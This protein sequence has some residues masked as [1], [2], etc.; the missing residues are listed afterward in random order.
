[1]AQTPSAHT[2]AAVS[3]VPTPAETAWPPVVPPPVTGSLT[4]GGAETLTGGALSCGA[5]GGA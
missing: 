4:A 2:M 3:P 1:M 5:A